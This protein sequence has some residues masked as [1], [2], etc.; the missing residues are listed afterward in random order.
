VH[1]YQL[2]RG[3]KRYWT[4]GALIGDAIH[5]ISD[6]GGATMAIEGRR[7]AGTPRGPALERFHSATALDWR[8]PPMSASGPFNAGSSGGRTG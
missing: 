3:R 4:P 1:P 8:W 2:W 7:R 5:V 6:D